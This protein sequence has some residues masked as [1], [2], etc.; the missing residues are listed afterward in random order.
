M[1]SHKGLCLN[2]QTKQN[3]F[4]YDLIEDRTTPCHWPSLTKETTMYI[5]HQFKV[6]Y[7]Y[8]LRT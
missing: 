4:E 7:I 5:I 2:K 6:I 3:I 8:L 1:K